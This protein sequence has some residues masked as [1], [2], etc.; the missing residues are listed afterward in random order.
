MNDVAIDIE[1]RIRS[2]LLREHRTIERMRIDPSLLH[3]EAREQH[4][5]TVATLEATWERAGSLA[6]L[7]RD[8]RPD[9]QVTISSRASSFTAAARDAA[10]TAWAD[11]VVAGATWL[12]SPWTDST[13]T[14]K[15]ER[16]QREDDDTGSSHSA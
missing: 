11:Y 5:E 6:A 1:Q 12:M 10:Q 3:P 13:E 16:T 2:E 9:D 14:E 15:N 8:E 4:A 7:P